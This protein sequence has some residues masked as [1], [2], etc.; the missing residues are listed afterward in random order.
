MDNV[1]RVGCWANG[2]TSWGWDS[3][4][5]LQYREDLNKDPESWLNKD[6]R[7]TWL[8]IEQKSEFEQFDDQYVQ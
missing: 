4:G 2:T 5:K 6:N 1:S 7:A 3:H 8:E